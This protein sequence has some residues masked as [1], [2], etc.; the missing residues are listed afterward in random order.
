MPILDP[1]P[2]FFSRQVRD[3]RRFHL[4]PRPSGSARLSVVCG[5][6]ERCT[7]N[8]EIRRESFPYF[9]IELV[10]AGELQVT[11]GE[12]SYALGVGALF[13]Y[14]PGIRQ[15]LKVGSRGRLHK[16]FVNFTGPGAARAL[17]RAGA[18]PGT[19]RQLPDAVPLRELFDAIISAGLR[20]T[21]ATPAICESILGALLL[22][23]GDAAVEHAPKDPVALA[24]FLRCREQI[25]ERISE[26]RSLQEA[27]R[28]CA[29]TAPYLCRLFARYGRES[30]FRMIERLR[31]Q[32]AAGLLLEPG[33]LVKNVA[34][35]LGYS[36]PFHFSRA[37][38]RHFG[39]APTQ[40][41]SRIG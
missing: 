33:A 41:A 26:I 20:R 5:G 19:V 35:E 40:I 17:E 31:M 23:V 25:E 11:L 27:A 7:T 16:Y 14:G 22:T 37:F 2:D 24:S 28:L 10:T 12:D 15:T 34:R 3:A 38:K 1:Q 4:A 6:W 21:Q 32:R 36:D 8:Y 13:S 30:P 9:V 18:A 29:V 39:F